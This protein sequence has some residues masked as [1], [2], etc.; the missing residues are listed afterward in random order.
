MKRRHDGGRQNDKTQPDLPSI[1]PLPVAFPEGQPTD[2][3][4]LRCPHCGEE[5]LVVIVDPRRH[6]PEPAA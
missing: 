2:R 1:L 4:K 6:R 3:D 5:L